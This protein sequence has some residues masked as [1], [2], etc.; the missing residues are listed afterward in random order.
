MESNGQDVLVGQ[1]GN[2]TLYGGND[3]DILVGGNGEDIFGI[4]SLVGTDDIRDFSDG[5]D[6]FALD[7]SIGFS[8]LT[9]QNNPGGTAAFIRDNT[10][11]GQVLAIIRN[12]DAAD[13]TED[14]FV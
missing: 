2:D 9:I 13:I 11:N 14:D 10:N 1:E 7:V 3:N 8:D 4:Q 5:I 12:V 6:S